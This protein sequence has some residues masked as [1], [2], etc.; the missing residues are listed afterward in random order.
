M[1]SYVMIKVLSKPQ[2]FIK[3]IVNMKI[4][5]SKLNR[6]RSYITLKISY[7]DYQKIENQ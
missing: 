4:N 7:A 2:L 3:R 6:Y 5:Y 1:N